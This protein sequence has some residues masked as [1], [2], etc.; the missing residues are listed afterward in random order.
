MDA[1]AVYRPLAEILPIVVP[2]SDQVTEPFAVNCRVWEAVRY[3]VAGVMERVPVAGGLSV[4]VAEENFAGSATLVAVT[5]TVW[6]D[7]IEAGAEYRPAV[8]IEPTCGLKVQLTAVLPK[9]TT[10]AVNCWVWEAASDAV[11]GVT[12]T[13]T[14]GVN[15][16]V[17]EVDFVESAVLVAV[18]VTV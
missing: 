1:G 16:R 18:T 13:D 11:A 4:M 15:V 7:G 6:V 9:P 10:V 17:A 8:E 2:L 14:A 3:T 12:V 5:V